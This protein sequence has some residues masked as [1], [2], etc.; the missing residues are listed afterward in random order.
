M[1]GA[2]ARVERGEAGE[3][4]GLPLRLLIAVTLL[5]I[6]ASSSVLVWGAT[7]VVGVF[8]ASVE[9]R[10]PWF[11]S[12]GLTLGY[13]VTGVYPFGLQNVTYNGVGEVKV[14][15]VAPNWSLELN[16]TENVSAPE[17]PPKGIAYDDPF[18]PSLLPILP[19]FLVIPNNYSVLSEGYAL[20]F[21]YDGNA[22]YDLGGVDVAA[23]RYTVLENVY[24]GQ[25]VS[26]VVKYFWVDASNGVI[27]NFTLANP[28]LHALSTSLLVNFSSPDVPADSLNFSAPLYAEPGNYVSYVSRGYYNATI[29]Y[30]TVFSEPDGE[31][32]FERS[33]VEGGVQQSPE[34]F[35][36]NYTAPSFYPASPRLGSTV[37]F[38]VSQGEPLVVGLDALGNAT[39]NTPAGSFDTIAYANRSVGFEAYISPRTGVAV[40]MELPGGFL[41]LESSNFVFPSTLGIPLYVYPAVLIILGV[42]A[43]L[44]LRRIRLSS[45]RVGS[46][47]RGKPARIRTKSS[48]SRLAF[49]AGGVVPQGNYG[50]VCD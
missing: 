15:S 38:G 19:S 44:I 50:C 33:V 49:D 42:A 48:P 26:P 12:P 41:E 43:W 18:F 1:L 9:E 32:M 4:C 14:L 37:D 2:G 21:H 6:T 29:S 35:L 8:S 24:G 46:G 47:S 23:Y 40:Y 3:V 25:G 11:A 34:F 28:S 13:R 7:G 5:V 36:D 20:F 22:T 17:L 27:L 10:L 16:T 39:V 31:F 30:R 45:R